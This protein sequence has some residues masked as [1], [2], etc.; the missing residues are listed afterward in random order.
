[1]ETHFLRPL[2]D[3]HAAWLYAQ[4]GWWTIVGF[5]GNF[6]FGS[7]FVFQWIAS[8]RRREIVVPPFF[9]HLSFWGSVLNLLY[10]LHLDSA[11]LICGVVFLPVLYGRNL[12]LLYRARL[13]SSHG[14]TALTDRDADDHHSPE[15]A[16][17]KSPGA[18]C[19]R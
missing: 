7:R 1:M 6:L 16:A 12:W 9:W 8:E 14:A 13:S 2:L 18:S 5:T 17:W 15:L 19:L 11:P 4:S 10:C 3:A